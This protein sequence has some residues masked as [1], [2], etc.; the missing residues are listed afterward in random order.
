MFNVSV[1]IAFTWLCL[2]G[3]GLG[4]SLVFAPVAALPVMVLLG[5][6]GLIALPVLML[7]GLALQVT[8]SILSDLR[9]PDSTT[10]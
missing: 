8:T 9:H 3:M 6:V 4:W 2:E 10:H 7:L 1:V 5:L